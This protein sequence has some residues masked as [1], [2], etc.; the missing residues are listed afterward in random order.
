VK[1]S[2]GEQNGRGLFRRYD[3]INQ[4]GSVESTKT[5]ISVGKQL[6]AFDT[7][8][9]DRYFRILLFLLLTRKVDQFP[10]LKFL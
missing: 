3:L 6:L 7:L 8:L 2:G 1:L 4:W 10:A 5:K 9:H